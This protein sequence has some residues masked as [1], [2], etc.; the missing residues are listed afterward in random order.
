MPAVPVLAQVD[1]GPGGSVTPPPAPDGGGGN[2]VEGAPGGTAPGGMPPGGQPPAA[3]AGWWLWLPMILVL[4]VLFWTSITSQRRERKKKDAMIAALRKHDKV[5]TIG[6]IIGSVIETK[7]NEI[8]LKVDE[9]NNIKM[10]FSPSAIQQVLTS[11][12]SS[13]SNDDASSRS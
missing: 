6:G 8:V 10:R 13:S 4:V 12:G 2:G 11:G 9:A 3:G 1:P 7:P 5:Q